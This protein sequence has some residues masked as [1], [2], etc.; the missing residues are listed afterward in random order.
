MKKGF[1]LLMV[2]PLGLTFCGSGEQQVTSSE[3]QVASAEQQAVVTSF[4][5]Y[6]ASQVALAGDNFSAAGTALAE[7]ATE[8]TGDLKVLAEEAAQAED[9]ESMRTAF[10]PLSEEVA[11]LDLPEGLVVAFCPMANNSQGANWVQAD[12]A[13][14]NPYFGSAMLDCGE[15][16][17]EN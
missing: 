4:Q 9:I 8:S 14:N 7:L 15:I 6:V 5:S 17:Q 10:I 3:Q 16:V 1:L 2:L 13:I 12:G 11:K